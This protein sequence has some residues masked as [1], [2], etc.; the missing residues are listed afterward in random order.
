MSDI[1]LPVCQECH[2]PEP[3]CECAA[4]RCTNCGKVKSDEEQGHDL[5][6]ACWWE[7]ND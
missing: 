1:S 4:Y 3:Y 5:C 2:Q 6:M 7:L